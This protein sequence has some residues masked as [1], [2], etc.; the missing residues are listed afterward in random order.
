MKIDYK[1][2]GSIEF[3]TEDG[4]DESFLAEIIKNVGKKHDHFN[5]FFRLDTDEDDGRDL[6]ISHALDVDGTISGR[7]LK[8]IFSPFGF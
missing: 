8:L 2:W 1:A 5:S 4:R 7:V 3:V 6:S